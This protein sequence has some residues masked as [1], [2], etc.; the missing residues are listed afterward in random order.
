[1]KVSILLLTLLDDQLGTLQVLD[2][3]TSFDVSPIGIWNEIDELIFSKVSS[4]SPLVQSNAISLYSNIH[5]QDF[6]HFQVNPLKIFTQRTKL[7]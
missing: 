6:E 1:M 4:S 3:L 2:G 7:N 5:V